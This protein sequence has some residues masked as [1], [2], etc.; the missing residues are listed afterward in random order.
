[1]RSGTRALRRVEDCAWSTGEITFR[2]LVRDDG[3]GIDPEVLKG[4][5]GRTFRAVGTA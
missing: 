5:E 4:R 1:M 2:L 3:Q